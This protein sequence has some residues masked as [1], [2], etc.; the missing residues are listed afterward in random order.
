MKLQVYG[1]TGRVDVRTGR[2]VADS[3]VSGDW[4]P[5]NRN[6]DESAETPD[7]LTLRADRWE[8]IRVMANFTGTPGGAETIT[9]QA[10]RS[11]WQ[12]AV[13][14]R[15]WIPIGDP[16]VLS[17]TLQSDLVLTDGCD[18]AFR[19]TN[20]SLNGGTDVELVA[21]GGQVSRSYEV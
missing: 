19:I 6:A 3:P 12:A 17:P 14:G 9:I 18:V 10:I 20:L 8:D 13:P 5:D 11:V 4:T 2:T 7:S 15:F 16:I 1:P 21:L